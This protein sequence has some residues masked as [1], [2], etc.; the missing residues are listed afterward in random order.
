MDKNT[1]HVF[2]DASQ[3][4]DGTCGAAYIVGLDGKPVGINVTCRTNIEAELLAMLAGLQAA[5]LVRQHGQTIFVHSDLR[6]I[7]SILKRSLFKS[8]TPAAQLRLLLERT[9]S[10]IGSDAKKFRQYRRCH[11]LAQ[12]M[13][14]CRGTLHPLL[15]RKQA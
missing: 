11:I 6:G 10:K 5:L 7:H 2:S 4:A 12:V 15:L 13:A 8:R 14:G 3:H 1:V 9:G